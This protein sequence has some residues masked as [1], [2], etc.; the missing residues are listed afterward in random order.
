MEYVAA[1]RA[2]AHG[3]D[4]ARD[5]SGLGILDL[6]QHRCDVERT[7]DE[8]E[9]AAADRRDDRDLVAVRELVPRLDVLPVDGVEQPGRLVAETE[10]GPDVLDAGDVVE[11]ETRASGAFPEAGEEADGDAHALILPAGS[12]AEVALEQRSGLRPQVGAEPVGVVALLDQHEAGLAQEREVVVRRRL[13][14]ADLL[15]RVRE[16][17][18]PGLEPPQQLQP[19]RVAQRLVDAD[20]LGRIPG[21]ACSRSSVIG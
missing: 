12:G 3:A 15:G 7:F 10:G 21:A 18:R 16:R 17:D 2:A 4:E 14:E 5:R 8:A 13:R 11:L 20:E 6:P 19:A 1:A 9:R